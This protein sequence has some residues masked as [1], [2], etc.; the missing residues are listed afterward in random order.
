MYNIETKIDFYTFS[1]K[2]PMMQQKGLLFNMYILYNE[3]CIISTIKDHELT[4]HYAMFG[5][6]VTFEN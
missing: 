4:F 6:S 1:F 5:G 2:L 3:Y